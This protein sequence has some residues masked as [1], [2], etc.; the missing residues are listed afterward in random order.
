[1]PE[2]V[3]LSPACASIA[4]GSDNAGVANPPD[5]AIANEMPI[6]CAEPAGIPDSKSG[7]QSFSRAFS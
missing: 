4:Q 5:A 2:I 1:M 3:T 7:T 6:F